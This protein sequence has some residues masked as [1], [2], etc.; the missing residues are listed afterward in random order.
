MN[1]IILSKSNTLSLPLFINQG[2]EK[3]P[4][5][6]SIQPGDIIYV[7]IMEQHQSFENALIKKLYDYNDEKD[8]FGNM[9]IKISPEDTDTI[10][11]GDYYLT[12]K[13]KRQFEDHYEINTVIN[14]NL[15]TIIE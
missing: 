13:L 7:G 10:L 8:E 15:L 1:K 5:R 12:I 14:K 2:T 11:P 3:S 4:S 9:I 6:Y